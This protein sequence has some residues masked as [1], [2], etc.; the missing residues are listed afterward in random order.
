VLNI[1]LFP[2]AKQLNEV[3]IQ[4][5][6]R[7]KYTNKENPAVEL[8][9]KVIANKEKN[10]PEAYNYVEYKEY[11]KMQFSLSNL[12]EK[13]SEKKFFRKYKFIFENRD[14]TSYAGK[15]LLPIYLVEK[16]SQVYYRKNPEKTKVVLLGEKGVNF[17]AAVDN[18]GVGQYFKHLYEKVDI[19]DNSIYLLGRQFLSPIADAAPTYY[20]FFITDTITTENNKKLVRLSFTPRN[21][22]DVLFE[23][24]IY[25][26]LDGNYAVQQAGLTINKNINVNFVRMMHVDQ[27]F[28]LNPDG[29]YH[30]SR[31]NT[32]ADFGVTAKRK[33]GLFGIRTLTYKNYIVNK[34]PAGYFIRPRYQLRRRRGKASQRR[35]LGREPPG[36]ILPQP[37]LR[38]IKTSTALRIW[39]RSGVRQIWLRFYWPVIKALVSLRLAR[40]VLSTAL[41]LLKA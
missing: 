31:S 22:N 35:V 39:P 17:G 27:N 20:K 32:Y 37:N 26:T 14:S 13:I 25:I 29:R 1:K 5:A 18:E 6:K 23:G 9:R 36:Y 7:A 3:T 33:G 34:S 30:L 12:S 19:Y 4:A 2:S 40:P 11:D 24:D 10:R 15:S 21:T 28:E 8:I 41:T 38:F 16:L